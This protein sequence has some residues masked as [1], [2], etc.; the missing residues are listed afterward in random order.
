MSRSERLL[1]L[2]QLLRRYRLPVSG[3]KLAN[4]LGVSLRTSLYR[5]IASL[6]AQGAMIE[7]GRGMGYILQPGFMLPPLMFS[8]DEIEALVLGSRWVSKRADKQLASAASNA[9][10]KIAAVLPKDLRGNM[11]NNALFV[12]PHDTVSP[13]DIDLGLVRK[14]IRTGHKLSI[15]YSDQEGV[16]SQRTIWPFAIGFFE[17]SR[18]LVSWCELRDD[19]RHFR[20][21]RISSL[22]WPGPQYPRSKQ[23]LLREWRKAQGI[24]TR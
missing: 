5:D 7:G 18:L 15:T 6:Q 22:S 11:D 9:L 13:E 14:A 1:E 19:F 10:A 4:D 17:T 21:D 12:G 24:P 16:E 2:L 3:K 8:D 23:A 20:T